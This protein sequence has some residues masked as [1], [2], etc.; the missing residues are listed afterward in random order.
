M[1]QCA[2]YS[3]HAIQCTLYSV[4]G[5]VYRVE[6]IWYTVIDKV[7]MVQ[8]ICHGVQGTMYRLQLT[9][10]SANNHCLSFVFAIPLH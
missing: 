5:T 10:H 3:V 8:C 6:Y 7:Y 1:V 2:W 4:L 9:G